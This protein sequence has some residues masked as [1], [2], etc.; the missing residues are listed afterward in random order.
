MNCHVATC[1]YLVHGT[2]SFASGLARDRA[3]AEALEQWFA[4]FAK[5]GERA[6]ALCARLAKSGV[7]RTPSAREV[8]DL[9]VFGRCPAPSE[10]SSGFAVMLLGSSACV[11]AAAPWRVLE[12]MTQQLVICASPWIDTSLSGA[13]CG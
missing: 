8:A 10:S 13:V 3:S 6:Q 5:K 12:L 7:A 4:G 1:G 2:L 11:P 9:S